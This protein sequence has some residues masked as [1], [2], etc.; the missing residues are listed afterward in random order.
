MFSARSL[1][2]WPLPLMAVLAPLSAAQAEDPP[3]R[4]I[5][6]VVYG[7]DPCPTDTGSRDEIIVCARKPEAERYRI[8]KT[9]REKPEVTG[10]PGWASQ[11][12]A[13]DQAGQAIT[14]NSCSPNGS[15]GFTGCT[16]AMLRQWHAEK[17]M[18]ESAGIP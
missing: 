11:V 15:Y 9:L 7:D 3:Q 13:M 8:P 18:R 12:A 2:L 4:V 16:Q 10:G 5:A 1:F 17:R 14:P 6:L